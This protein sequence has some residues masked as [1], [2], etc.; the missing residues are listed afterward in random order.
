M[1]NRNLF[2]VGGSNQPELVLVSFNLVGAADIGANGYT[3]TG[4]NGFVASAA[5]T[6]EGIVQ[7]TFAD[8]YAYCCGFF[9][10]E[11]TGNLRC[12]MTAQSI[13]DSTP[14]VDLT[15]ETGSTGADID[16]DGLT[17][18]CNFLMKNSKYATGA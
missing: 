12:Q 7:I 5:R 9:H 16:P 2:P 14:T 11:L 8:S 10:G 3:I 15:F 18:R 1:A 17:V 6:A 13:A 4:S